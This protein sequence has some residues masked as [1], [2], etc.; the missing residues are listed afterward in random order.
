MLAITKSG[1]T[2]QIVDKMKDVVTDPFAV[3][4]IKVES[5]PRKDLR[6]LKKVAFYTKHRGNAMEDKL[7]YIAGF[8]RRNA[9][10]YTFDV[11]DR[12]TGEITKDVSV[13][14]YFLRRYNLRLQHWHLPLVETTKKGIVFPM[15]CCIIAPNQRYLYRL[16]DEQVRTMIKFAVSRP[17]QRMISIKNGLETLKWDSD[18]IL[19]RY[20]IKIADQMLTTKARLLDAPAVQFQ[21]SVVTPGVSGRWD[22]KGRKFL[23]PNPASL[24]SWGVCV[25][26]NGQFRCD[27]AAAKNFVKRFIEVYQSHGGRVDNK[28]PPIVSGHIDEGKAVEAT[29]LAAGNQGMISACE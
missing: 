27:D 23:H 13:Y 26:N 8:T 1:D 2:H 12:E 14:D 9:K 11:K 5:Y 20:G 17:P 19:N 25:L 4:P 21:G 3:P 24:Q 10:E 29:W 16:D 7:F 15:E 6:R 22:L 18:P 28:D